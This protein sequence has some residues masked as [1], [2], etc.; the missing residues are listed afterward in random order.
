MKKYKKIAKIFLVAMM[1]FLLKTENVVASPQC[2]ITAQKGTTVNLESMA[3]CMEERYG[4]DKDSVRRANKKQTV[5]TVEISFNKTDPKEGEKIIAL[6]AP[7]GFKTDVSKLYY[8]WYIIHTDEEGR[9][10]NSIEDGKREAMGII[11]RGDFE[12]DLFGIDYSAVNPA[13]EDEDGYSASYG[14][15]DGV[16]AKLGSGLGR[17]DDDPEVM[18][19]AKRQIVKHE[20][21]T[22]CYDH[23]FGKQVGS[24]N[25]GDSEED[26]SSGRDRIA[27]CSHE[28][29][30][31]GVGKIGDGEFGVAEEA[32]WRTDPYNA[33][34]DGDGIEDEADLAGLNQTQFTWVYRKGDR[35]GLVIEGTSMIPI[36]EGGERILSETIGF[37]VIDPITGEVR[38]FTS[39]AEVSSFCSSFLPDSI[40]MGDTSATGTGGDVSV[41]SGSG[42]SASVS[43]GSASATGGSGGSGTGAGGTS[44]LDVDLDADIADYNDGMANYDACD[45]SMEELYST[46]LDPN[47][48][49]D[50]KLNAY[51]KIMW[52]SPSICSTHND[53]MELQFSGGTPLDDDKCEPDGDGRL[54]YLNDESENSDWGFN[55]LATTPVNETGGGL[56]DP[57]LSVIPENPQFDA[58]EI[59][60]ENKR[61]D[62]IS[63]NATMSNETVNEDFLFYSW[64]V[65]RC[66]GNDFSDCNHP[67]T[68]LDYKTFT[69]GMGI[70]ELQFYPTSDVFG[71]LA[72]SPAMAAT[73]NKAWVRVTVIVSEHESLAGGTTPA[74]DGSGRTVGAIEKIYFPIVK[75]VVGINLYKA[76]RDSI[77]GTW[78][79]GPEKICDTGLYKDICPVYPYEVLIAETVTADGTV[80]FDRYNW[81][82]NEKKIDPVINCRIFGGAGCGTMSEEEVFFPV[83]GT[84]K[85]LMS[86]TVSN[87]RD[88]STEGS[89]DFVS[90]RTLSIASPQA[91]IEAVA[92]ATATTRFDGTLSDEVYEAGN[93]TTVT[94][95]AIPV[96]KY[97]SINTGAL[98]ED[99][100]VDL[101]WYINNIKVDNDFITNNT[102]LLNTVLNGDQ[103]TFTIPADMGMGAGINLK[104][105]VIKKFSSGGVNEYT[106]MLK[107]TWGII[108][109]HTLAK[110]T[111]IS[112][113]VA[114]N[115][116]LAQD[117]TLKQYLAS[118]ISN[119]PHY[120][121]F[122]IR[123]AIAMVLVWSVLF[124]LFYAVNL[125]KEV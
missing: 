24:V 39:R 116:A 78:R 63:V 28:F 58:V 101:E 37:S 88:N 80:D 97:L 57:E 68:N 3:E 43:D 31:C 9:A 18:F 125:N 77:T 22:R 6:S 105:R 103:I 84:E 83:I 2:D 124:G 75:N 11:A 82:I 114:F 12:P 111:S 36:L 61:S 52:A 94:F 23:N 5:P 67:I 120:L 99:D 102:M 123:L 72:G 16:G 38:I 15:A 35:I 115:M 45:D 30:K 27:R 26:E 10:L 48:G 98:Q 110:D 62:L 112:V 87:K 42:G 21:I 47:D 1:C 79:R 40:D 107:D 7:K 56:L 13:L 89:S 118:S 19:D 51:Y 121:I 20:S 117:V 8:T 54:V 25:M 60:A 73:D 34:T 109:S 113:K 81:Q 4:F 100:E 66:E 85:D 119:A 64:Q 86:I 104:A 29:A 59:L 122:T 46:R 17:F 55:Y 96:P 44:A 71:A 92:G 69:E 70:R 14:G 65:D 76:V 33:D 74:S 49:E 32:C 93:S 95:K 41:S 106:E 50:G 53:S 90:E 108:N 91:V